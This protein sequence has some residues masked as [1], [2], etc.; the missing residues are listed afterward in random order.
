MKSHISRIIT[1][2][3]GSFCSIPKISSFTILFVY[4][5]CVHRYI[6]NY[7]KNELYC[8]LTAFSLKVFLVRELTFD[9]ILCVRF[10]IIFLAFTSLNT[11]KKTQKH[12][13]QSVEVAELQILLVSA[14]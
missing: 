5:E 3:K 12:P 6:Y 9:V 10:V 13:S 7:T 1:Y 2:F 14:V 8:C 4:I 11:L